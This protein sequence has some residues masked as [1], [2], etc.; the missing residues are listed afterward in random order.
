MSDI[1]GHYKTYTADAPLMGKHVGTYWWGGVE[2]AV[3]RKNTPRRR[4]A[5]SE[6]QLSFDQLMSDNL[7]S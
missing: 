7:T 1:K 6:F 5:V 3:T 2:R 4:V